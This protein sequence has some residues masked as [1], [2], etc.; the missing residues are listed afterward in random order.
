MDFVTLQRLSIYIKLHVRVCVFP[1][2]TSSLEGVVLGIQDFAS[3]KILGFVKFWG[4][5]NFGGHS[6]F[7]VK[8]FLG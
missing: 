7:G 2:P 6:F 5:F 1:L 8:K 4:S 3:N